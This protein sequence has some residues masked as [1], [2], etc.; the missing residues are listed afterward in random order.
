MF[1]FSEHS[2]ECNK[3]HL[4]AGLSPDPLGSSQRSPGPI[5]VL[6]EEKG[7]EGERGREGK[8]MGGEDRGGEDSKREG[9]RGGKG[10]RDKKAGKGREAKMGRKGS[11]GRREMTKFPLQ[12]SWIRHCL[13]TESRS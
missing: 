8:V 1:F 12:K 9:T 7:R 4:A 2:V 10:T 3:L 11:I 6:G 5:A 13:N